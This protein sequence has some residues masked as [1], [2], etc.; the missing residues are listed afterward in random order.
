ML[1]SEQEIHP[2][3]CPS[4]NATETALW[5]T[6]RVPADNQ[7]D[8]N[9]ASVAGSAKP[10]GSA[11]RIMEHAPGCVTQTRRDHSIDYCILLSGEAELILD[12]GH[13]VLLSAGDAAVLRGTHQAWRNPNA[14]TSC[15]IAVCTIEARNSE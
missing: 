2:V 14:D 7:T 11:F 10:S 8:E 12:G 3:A 1:L 4:L 6:E 9:A 15:K 5:N 13:G